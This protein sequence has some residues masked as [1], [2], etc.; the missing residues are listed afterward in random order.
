MGFSAATGTQQAER[1]AQG[2]NRQHGASSGVA[3]VDAGLLQSSCDKTPRLAPA[4]RS[5]NSRQATSRAAGRPSLA[6]RPEGVG[7]NSSSV[8]DRSRLQNGPTDRQDTTPMK[9]CALHISDLHRDAENPLRNPILLDSLQRDRDR[10]VSDDTRPIGP[11]DLVIVSGD[12][13]QGVRYDAPDAEIAL[14]HQYEEAREFLTSLAEAFVGGDHERVV[15]VPGN[16]DISDYIFRKSLEEIDTSL[17]LPAKR[18]LVAQLFSP[19]SPLRWSWPEL[20]LHRISNP[21]IYEQRLATF[22]DF[23]NSFYNAQR[24]YSVESEKQFDVFDYPDWGIA[25]VGFSSC[26]NN[27]PMNRQGA[28]HPT[29]VASSNQILRPASSAGKLRIAVW[30]HNIEGAPLQ[31]DY[32]DPD[33]LQNLIDGGYSLGFHG[34]QH[35]P[36]HLNARFHYGANRR[37]TVISAGTLCGHSAYGFKRSYNLVELDT[38]ALSGRLHVRVMQNDDLQMPIWGPGSAGSDSAS[39][40]EFGIDAPPRPF[41]ESGHAARQL[42]AAAEHYENRQYGKAARTLLPLATSEELV[43]PLLLECLTQIED[44]E[45]VVSVFDPP[46]SAGE[47]IGVMDALWHQ[48]HRTRLAEVLRIPLISQSQD[49][50]VVELRTKYEARLGA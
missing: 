14:M 3:H 12:I 46:M 1:Q 42:A 17:G 19:E 4:T 21:E 43:R 23:Y 9:L 27:D 32:M 28:I 35:R 36:Q 16:H 40:L 50:S 45:T 25:V 24:S 38:T 11:P 34:H 26:H 5:D 30:H 49:S 7:L 48:G 47:A 13:V 18:R 33:T 10:Y 2:H 39:S 22:V 41:V 37:I 29:C 6:R 44:F 20:S 15:I 8:P 31:V